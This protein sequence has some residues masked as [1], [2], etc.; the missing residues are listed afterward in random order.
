MRLADL[1][2]AGEGGGPAFD[3]AVDAADETDIA[4]AL[5]LATHADRDV[6]LA[7]T[8]S[9]PMLTHGDDPTPG[10]VNTAI[11]LS[12]DQENSVRDLACLALGSQ[13]RTVDTVGLRDALTARLDDS[14]PDTRCEALVGLAYRRDPRALPAVRAALSRPNGELWHLELL[15][16]GALSD[17]GLHELVLQHQTGWEDDHAAT[18]DLVRRLTDPAGPGDD[19]LDGVAELYRRRA[20]GRADDDA[21]DAWRTLDRMIDI[22]PHRAAEFMEAAASRLAGDEAAER[23]LRTNSA[24]AQLAAE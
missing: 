7:V 13:W 2:I 9:L 5:K 15:A 21:I 18:A 11:E 14:D 4:A 23:E 20:N 24:M 3:A 16:A 10:I 1:L 19:V 8:Q 22:A 6:R 12:R 17:P